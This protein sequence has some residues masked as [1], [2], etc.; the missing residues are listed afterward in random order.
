MHTNVISHIP[1][2][3]AVIPDYVS[4]FAAN[5]ALVP[6]NV[7]EAK[8]Y[9]QKRY[10][11]FNNFTRLS[12]IYTSDLLTNAMPFLNG[13]HYTYSFDR[14]SVN[15]YMTIPVTLYNPS[16]YAIVYRIELDNT[17]D[18]YKILMDQYLN[19]THLYYNIN[20]MYGQ[21]EVYNTEESLHESHDYAY[22]GEMFS[23]NPPIPY[24]VLQPNETVC[25]FLC[26]FRGIE[27]RCLLDLPPLR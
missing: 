2:P 9:V 3:V 8:P 18:R 1:I 25:P 6:F 12:T 10:Q 4:I 26:L 14:L 5:Q 21:D 23:L 11:Y 16:T 7:T 19:R 17:K 20:H 24:G 22:N 13:I 27:S 15:H